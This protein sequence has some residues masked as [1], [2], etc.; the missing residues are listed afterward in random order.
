MLGQRG[1]LSDVVCGRGLTGLQI[2]RSE[3][4]SENRSEQ[5]LFCCCDGRAAGSGTGM[6][7][8]SCRSGF[9]SHRELE[10]TRLSTQAKSGSLRGE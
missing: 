1:H 9:H 7:L 3:R 2:G 10:C 5:S 6:L 4:S 8:T